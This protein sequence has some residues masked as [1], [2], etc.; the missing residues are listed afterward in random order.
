MVDAHGA[1]CVIIDDHP[2]IRAGLRLAL[3][4]EGVVAV[5]GEAGTGPDGLQMLERLRPA[6]A[7]IDMRL[8]GMDGIRVVQAAR[9]A[10]VESRLVLLTALTERHL[11]E[12]AFAAGADGYVGKDSELSVTVQALEA[13]LNGRRFVDPTLASVLFDKGDDLLTDRELEVLRE[14]GDG[15]QNKVIALRLSL[16]EDTVKTHVAA[17]MRKLDASSRTEAVASAIRRALI[18]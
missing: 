7:L 13:V 5:V 10:G 9:Q 1:T 4:S 16:S 3:E 2:A 17:V 12:Q 6:V 8:P 14:M 15:S 11:I 18:E